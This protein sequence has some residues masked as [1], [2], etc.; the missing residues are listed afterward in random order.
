MI[1]ITVVDHRTGQTR[2][3]AGSQALVL[4]RNGENE[5][6]L[7]LAGECEDHEGLQDMVRAASE[8]VEES[9]TEH[10]N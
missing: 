2:T 8:L 4:V 1:T 5:G 3:L 9:S 7:C 6:D 10:L